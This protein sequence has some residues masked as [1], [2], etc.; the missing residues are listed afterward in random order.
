MRKN[1][2]WRGE[3]R[4]GTRVVIDR[5]T[6]VATDL[7][8]FTSTR[9]QSNYDCVS[10][11]AA[12]S[13]SKTRRAQN[14]PD[15][16]RERARSG[17]C[18]LQLDRPGTVPRFRRF[19]KPSSPLQSTHSVTNCVGRSCATHCPCRESMQS[20]SESTRRSGYGK[21]GHLQTF[22]SHLRQ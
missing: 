21:N 3:V 16:H 15:T 7:R 12:H 17:P 2:W 22:R 8:E 18:H 1:G 11:S 5:Q 20:G 14:L 13:F 10:P 4:C 19:F 6:E 9:V